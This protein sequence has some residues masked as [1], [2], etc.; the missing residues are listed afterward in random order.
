MKILTVI[1]A[2]PQFIKASPVS[3][4]IANQ[5]HPEGH[6]R[7]LEI[8]VHTGQHY[9]YEMS[10]VFFDELKIPPPR[11]HLDV[12]AGRHGE[13]TGAM[14]S[15]IESVLMEERPDGVL[16]YGDTN[17]TLAGGLA[18]SKLHIP[19]I[20]VEAGLRSYNRRMPEE[21]NR[22]LTDHISTLLFCPTE[23]AVSNLKKEGI[24]EG[25]FTVGDVM[26]DAFLFTRNLAL[27]S[28][29]ILGDLGLTP[30]GYLLATIHR[31]ENTD[32][33]GNLKN[34]FSALEQIAKADCPVIL[35]VHPRTRKA[36]Q[37]KGS[38][39][40]NP[41]VRLIPPVGYLDMIALESRARIILTDSGGVQKEAYFSGVPCVTLREET[42][43]VET[44]ASGWNRLGGTECARILE[45]F[46]EAFRFPPC[47][48]AGF[49]GTGDASQRILNRIIEFGRGAAI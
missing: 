10:Q 12:R 14:L 22:V 21:V 19:V 30:G 48:Q 39:T 34:I 49:Y 41:H 40:A 11:Y 26:Y 31:Q 47:E 36:L 6:R 3:R 20:H 37:T 24:A 45:A 5:N 7:V 23:A 33:P 42:E 13:M 18:A 29:A 8:L 38:G 43:W 4:A 1:G 2:R 46:E 17:S 25:V 27:K 28:S 32:D 15:R 44:V 35:P 16:V 9:D